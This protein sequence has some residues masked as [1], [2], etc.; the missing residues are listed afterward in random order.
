MF[1]SEEE[2]VEYYEKLSDSKGL[3]FE[4]LSY[5]DPEKDMDYG[6]AFAFDVENDCSLPIGEFA[7]RDGSYYAL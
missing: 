1:N 2:L 5:E 6:Y 7:V 3:L 4:G